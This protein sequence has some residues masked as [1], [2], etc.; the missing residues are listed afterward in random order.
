LTQAATKSWADF[1]CANGVSV[2]PR[3]SKRSWFSWGNWNSDENIEVTLPRRYVVDVR[4]GG[5]SVQLRDAVGVATLRTSGGSI[6]A[7]NVTGNVEARTSR[8]SISLRAENWTDMACYR[9]PRNSPF[10]M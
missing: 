2:T 6:S 7:K 10:S 1:P 5:G 9:G 8:G 4:T 3:K